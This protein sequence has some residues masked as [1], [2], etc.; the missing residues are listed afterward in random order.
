[1]QKTKITDLLIETNAISLNFDQKF[2]WA[3][4][5]ISPIYCDN[6]I[7]LS[8]VK[9][10]EV[11]IDAFVENIK[12]NYPD[13]ELIAGVAT[14]GIG[15]AAMISQKMNLPMIYVRSQSKNHGKNSQIEGKFSKNQKVVVIEDL[16]STGQSVLNVCNALREESVEVLGVQ[17]IFTYQLSKATNNFANENVELKTLANRQDLIESMKSSQNY[18]LENIDDLNLFF[19]SLG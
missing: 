7:L 18:S 16:I 11:I 12:L 4:G 3:S 5:I 10:R 1:M 13:V 17:A 19:N 2:K 15:F 14:S 8:F 6:R 9:Q